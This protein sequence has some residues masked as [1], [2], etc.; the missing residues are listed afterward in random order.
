VP[1]AIREAMGETNLKELIRFEQE[2]ARHWAS[3]GN[4]AVKTDP[5]T[6]RDLWALMGDDPEKFKT[7]DLR[8]YGMKLSGEDYE[9]LSARQQAMRTGKGQKDM[10]PFTSKINATIEMNEWVG[11]K[12]AD[13]RGAFRRA[14][15]LDWERLTAGG[16]TLTPTQEDELLDN[17]LKDIVIKPG[18]LWDTKGPAYSA[19]R[20]VREAAQQFEAGKVYTDA[21]G[22]KAR[23]KGGG[24]WEDVK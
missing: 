9:Q 4:A 22:N 18:S 5:A 3:N 23:F 21:S 13:K 12:N 11:P 1:S 19:P 17:L 10:L 24:K 6:H 8:P 14:A 2:R 7:T 20:A 15:Q 16:K